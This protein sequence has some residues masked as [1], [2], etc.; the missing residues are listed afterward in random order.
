MGSV[1]GYLMVEGAHDI[2]V[3]EKILEVRHGFQL[4]RK[5]SDLDRVIPKSDWLR[6]IDGNLEKADQ[7]SAN[8]DDIVARRHVPYFL[9]DAHDRVIIVD[10]ANG[11]GGIKERLH[12]T[13]MNTSMAGIRGWGVVIDADTDPAAD[14]LA[15]LRRG[16][17][18]LPML[19]GVPGILPGPPRVGVHILPDNHQAGTLE[20]PLLAAAAISY[21]KTTGRARQF[22]DAVKQDPD[23][24]PG[25]EGAGV[26]DEAGSDKAT[27]AAVTA[28]LKPG[29]TTQASIA[30][31]AWV[32]PDT[33]AQT[34]LKHLDE[35]L[36][37]LFFA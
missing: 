19:P 32:T 7:Q 28:I 26:R 35:F 30:D 12:I 31:H 29:K 22:V 18:G 1:L 6:L 16:V 23:A 36:T 27:I 11:E 8:D 34:D 33:I 3:V 21:P 15:R 13:T 37:R 17:D 9:K 20:K 5:R 10:P 4:L 25:R 24:W 14:K 2:A